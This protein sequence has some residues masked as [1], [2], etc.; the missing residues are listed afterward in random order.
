MD[1]GSPLSFGSPISAARQS[2]LKVIKMDRGIRG[3]RSN[4]ILTAV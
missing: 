2:R 4:E 3:S 1:F